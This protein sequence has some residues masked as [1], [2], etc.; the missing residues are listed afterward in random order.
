MWWPRNALLLLLRGFNRLFPFFLKMKWTAEDESN[1]YQT[2][3]IHLRH[4]TVRRKVTTSR[5][6]SWF[7]AMFT[8]CS[9][10][11]RGWGIP[12]KKNAWYGCNTFTCGLQVGEQ[13]WELCVSPCP[14]VMPSLSLT[15]L[16][17]H[18]FAN[19]VAWILPASFISHKYLRYTRTRFA[20]SCPWRACIVLDIKVKLLGVPSDFLAQAPKKDQHDQ[21]SRRVPSLLHRIWTWVGT[22][23]ACPYRKSGQRHLFWKAATHHPWLSKPGEKGAAWVYRGI[24]GWAMLG[25]RIAPPRHAVYSAQC[26]SNL[27]VRLSKVLQGVCFS[28]KIVRSKS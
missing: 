3:Q 18:C 13:S 5:V 26:K 6:L 1:G 21:P 12:T 10:N 19:F 7:D 8:A 20:P 28:W 11:Y 25:F 22:A 9:W 23:F 17:F 27:R 2:P 16:E 15:A 24:L 4:G 14:F